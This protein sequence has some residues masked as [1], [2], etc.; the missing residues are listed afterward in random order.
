MVSACSATV[1][2]SFLLLPPDQSDRFSRFELI[3]SIGQI[4][5]SLVHGDP[6]NDGVGFSSDQGGSP[7]SA[8]Q[9]DGV[10]IAEG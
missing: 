7:V 6:A 8:M 2:K 5:Q 1:N 9:W 3:G 10:S 4:N